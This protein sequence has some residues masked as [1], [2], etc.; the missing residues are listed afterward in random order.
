MD[1]ALLEVFCAEYTRHL[2]R[3]RSNAVAS[4]EGRKAELAKIDREMERLVDAIVGGVPA[5]KVKDRMAGLDA[6]KTE[7]EALLADA[8]EPPPVLVHPRMGDR[9]RAEIGR[10]RDALND[11][12][13]REEAAEIVRGLIDAIV[14]RPSGTGRGRTLSIDLSGHLAGILNLARETKRGADGAPVSD[15]QIKLVAG[16]CITRYRIERVSAPEK[17]TFK[18]AP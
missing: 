16:A 5:A 10:L 18:L 17:I 1:P 11:V 3:L 7:L 4:S 6:R 13:R 2:N 9:Y 14:L 15:Q 8:P 12:A